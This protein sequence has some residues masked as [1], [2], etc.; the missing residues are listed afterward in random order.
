M[1]V[2]FTLMHITAMRLA[3]FTGM[4]QRHSLDYKSMAGPGG[5]VYG[6]SSEFVLFI[7]IWRFAIWDRQ[8]T[9]Y[10]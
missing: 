8:N 9:I 4:I 6:S 7:R 10:L 3:D 5:E 2:H 1:S